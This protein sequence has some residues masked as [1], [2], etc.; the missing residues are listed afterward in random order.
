MQRSAGPGGL[1]HEKSLV[2]YGCLTCKPDPPVQE[3]FVGPYSERFVALDQLP[4][5]LDL[6]GSGLY[7]G[8]PEWTVGDLIYANLKFKKLVE[9]YGALKKRAEKTLKGL[10]V[11]Y[12]SLD[13]ALPGNIPDSVSM[14][15]AGQ[16]LKT[17]GLA[18][19]RIVQGGEHFI[20]AGQS[21]WGGKYRTALVPDF[22]RYGKKD[23]EIN[24]FSVR[25]IPKP[26]NGFSSASQMPSSNGQ[27]PPEVP[28][29]DKIVSPYDKSSELPWFIA[30]VVNLVKYLENNKFEA[31][32]YV[33]CLFGV[34]LLFKRR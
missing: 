23:W 29:R 3:A 13:Q 31:L 26:R 2:F 15:Q 14:F 19:N 9:E 16:K 11:P 12:V 34:L 4:L 17:K 27:V 8:S 33:I 18:A 5:R 22:H 32:V 30:I 10:S 21:S 20:A 25:T 7:H 6:Y 28:E 24:P 1:N